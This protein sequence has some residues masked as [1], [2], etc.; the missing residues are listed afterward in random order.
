MIRPATESDAAG[1]AAYYCDIR[2]ATVPSIHPEAEVAEWIRTVMIPRGGSWVWEEGGEVVGWLDVHDGWVNQLQC[3]R[4]ATGKGIGKRLL[5]F[6]KERSPE[7][8][9]LWA[10]QVN[11]GARRFYAREGFI[12]EYWGDGADNEE[13][14]PDVRMVW[15]GTKK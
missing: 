7:E 5:D 3:A 13:G 9:R 2:L 4:G 12:E 14:E 11:T 1:I 15:S 10:F 8:L 6:A